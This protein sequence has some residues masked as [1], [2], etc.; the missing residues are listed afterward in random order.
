M[1]IAEYSSR[2]LLA[3]A[4]RVQ[5]RRM[6][7]LFWSEFLGTA[8]LILLG[9]ATVAS[10]LLKG[11]KGE[12]AGWLAICVGWSS[13]L[14]VAV[15]IAEKSGAHLNPAVSIALASVGEFDPAKLST[16]IAA[17]FLGAAAGQLAVVFAFMPHWS[18]TTDPLAKRACFCNSPAIRSLGWNLISEIIATFALVFGIMTLVQSP[19]V[20]GESGKVSDA[21]SWFAFAIAGLLLVIGIGLGGATGFAINPARDLAPRIVH[22]IIPLAGKGESDWGYAWVPVVGP[23]IGAVLAAHLACSF[24]YC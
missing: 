19:W 14:F 9:N 3:C 18:N 20:G 15:W 11:S 10:V 5:L 13:A 16:Y 24:G 6:V 7:D 2:D 8:F 17:Q 21:W 1:R 23:I 4:L 12:G 22:A